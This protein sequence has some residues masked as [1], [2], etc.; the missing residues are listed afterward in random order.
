[1][2]NSD[3]VTICVRRSWIEDWLASQFSCQVTGS[4]MKSGAGSLEH[5]Q[6]QARPWS[7]TRQTVILTIPLQDNRWPFCWGSAH[8]EYFS[9]HLFSICETILSGII[10]FP[11][12]LYF[13]FWTHHK[14]ACKK[15]QNPINWNSIDHVTR[16]QA[17]WH[18]LFTKSVS[19]LILNQNKISLPTVWTHS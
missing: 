19:Y 10:V 15:T 7:P 8:S 12:L 6:I 5:L 1:M 13:I 11:S 18:Q 4:N 3:W 9:Y 14:I 2:R 16:K 17:C